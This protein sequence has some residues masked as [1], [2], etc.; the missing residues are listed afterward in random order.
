MNPFYLTHLYPDKMSIYGDMGNIIALRYKLKKL[1]FDVM[2]QQVNS[3]DPMP[4]QS[5]FYFMGGGQDSDQFEIFQDLLAKK[6]KLIEEVELGVPLLSICGGYQLLGE[7][8]TT[9]SGK[10]IEGIGIF[11]VV[12]KSLDA[13]V[14]SRCIGNLV[15]S[16][17][18]SDDDGQEIGQLVGFENHGGQTRATENYARANAKPLGTVMVGY[19]N[20]FEDKLEGCVYKNAI[21]TY[22]HGS[23]LPKNPNL[24]NYMLTKALETKSFREEKEYKFSFPRSGYLDESIAHRTQAS[25]ITRW[26]AD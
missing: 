8:F 20:N 24:A 10:L 4:S 2:Y 18:L 3:G 14:K 1:G 17:S 13:S 7:Q 21:G 6:D 9:G 15:V 23:C 25:L 12:T 11:P 5:D 16:S 26:L 19:G 22:L